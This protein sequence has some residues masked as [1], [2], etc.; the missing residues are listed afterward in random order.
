MAALSLLALPHAAQAAPV[1]DAVAELQHDWEVVRYQV[2][3]NER[4][5]RF[6]ALATKAHKIS[7]TFDGRAEPLVWE[8]IIV[9]SWAGE[10]GGL[11]GLSLVKK[12]KL[13]YETAIRLDGNAL[14]GSAYNS[15][16]VLYYKVPGWPVG[17]GDKSKARELLQK[18]L[19]INPK[20][21]DANF[22]FAEYLVDTKKPEDAVA[23]LE[24]ALQAPARPGRQIADAGR[25][26][27][28]TQLLN[29]LKA[30]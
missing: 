1:D 22:F 21:I 25:R 6:E 7:E 29:T 11:G 30:R 10:K 18:A 4:E 13:L 17:F 3:A 14:D 27:E 19:A 8:G 23:Y 12:A 28:A 16:G 15:L 5:K 24:R 9:S 26:E 20:G 2:P